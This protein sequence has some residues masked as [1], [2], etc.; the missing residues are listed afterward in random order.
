MTQRREE[1]F[2]T[3]PSSSLSAACSNKRTFFS[4]S[5][6]VLFSL[7]LVF[8]SIS[9]H[10]TAH[11]LLVNTVESATKPKAPS[12]TSH[13]DSRN[14]TRKKNRKSLQQASA[15]FSPSAVSRPSRQGRQS[16]LF[17]EANKRVVKKTQVRILGRIEGF[18]LENSVRREVLPFPP[19]VG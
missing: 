13:F 5:L 9:R 17:V 8:S 10:A 12:L 14:V 6:F 4:L 1:S 15:T 11:S 19:F 7:S 18:L 3:Q 16:S 2:E